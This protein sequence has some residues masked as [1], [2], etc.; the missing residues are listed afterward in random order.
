MGALIQGE[1]Y[2][3]HIYLIVDG[4]IISKMDLQDSLSEE[5]KLLLS[6]GYKFPLKCLPCMILWKPEIWHANV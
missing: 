4:K 5:G 1:F 3:C 6:K 2:L